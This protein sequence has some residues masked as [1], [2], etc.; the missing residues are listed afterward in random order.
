MKT[1]TVILTSNAASLRATRSRESAPDDR[2]REAIQKCIRGAG[3]DCFVALLLAMTATDI[4]KNT[5]LTNINASST[6]EI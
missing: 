6:I 3:L 5:L 2:L 4:L 1:V